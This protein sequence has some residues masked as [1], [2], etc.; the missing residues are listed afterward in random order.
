MESDLG[1]RPFLP[2]TNELPCA[3]STGKNQV[4]KKINCS[5]MAGEKGTLHDPREGMGRAGIE[6]QKKFFN[7]ETTITLTEG[8]KKIANTL[9]KE[10]GRDRVAHLLTENEDPKIRQE[11]I[12][13][14]IRASGVLDADTKGKNR[15]T[16]KQELEALSDRIILHEIYAQV[17]R[18]A[19]LLKPEHTKDPNI[20]EKLKAIAK[21]M[22]AGDHDGAESDLLAL[23]ATI[24]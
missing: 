18:K 5:H 19:I 14:L 23:D 7:E 4:L 21:K 20:S 12:Y 22:A 9:L 6:D 16:I 8:Q 24:D 10:L 15:E 17:G 3:K 13:F 2:E 11:L 1:D